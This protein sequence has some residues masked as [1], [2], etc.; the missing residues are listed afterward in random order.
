MRTF[1]DGFDVEEE[2]LRE[3]LVRHAQCWEE[4]EID[5]SVAAAGVKKALVPRSEVTTLDRVEAAWSSFEEY[6]ALNR[7]ERVFRDSCCRFES[8]PVHILTAKLVAGLSPPEFRTKVATALDMKGC[9]TEHPD[10]VYTVAREATEAWATG[11]QFRS[12]GAVVRVGSAK[13]EKGAVVGR[14]GQGS[15]ARSGDLKSRGS[16]WNCGKESRR[17]GDCTTKRKSGPSGGQQQATAQPGCATSGQKSSFQQSFKQGAGPAS[18]A[19][20]KGTQ[21][22][23]RSCTLTR[24]VFSSERQQEG[25][26]I[27]TTVVPS[28]SSEPSPGRQ[29]LEAGAP[30]PAWRALQTNEV[31]GFRAEGVA[32][33][34]KEKSCLVDLCVPGAAVESVCPVTAILNTGSGIS[35]MS[36][37][38]AAKLQAAAPAD[39]IVGPMTDDQN[40]KMAD[41]KL[42]LVKQKSCPVRTAVHAMWGPVV[43]DPASY[44][45]LPGSEVTLGSP[46]LAALGIYVYDSLGERAR[47]LNL[48]VKGVV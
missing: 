3:A 20:G 37:S 14:G 44:T 26:D 24:D 46:T 47:K 22:G 15:C 2:K 48:S 12:K 38:V 6:F 18:R 43:M 9:W 25:L 32:V 45:T 10:L 27:S 34:E 19:S 28:V 35:T 21:Q 23:A 39:Q 8:G 31:T 16:C 33:D 5:P 1:F 40:V 17:M 29:P 13:E 4:D 36:E 42:V 7:I 30:E 11:V 41:G